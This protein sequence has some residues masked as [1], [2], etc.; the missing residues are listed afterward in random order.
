[1]ADIQ[2]GVKNY[3]MTI[4]E[5]GKEIIFLRKVEA[6]AA[7]KSYGIE[8]ARLAGLP[9]AVLRRAASILDRLEKK[10]IDLTGRSRRKPAEDMIFDEAQRSLF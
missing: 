4:Q 8:V 10:E 2:P 7:D 3:R 1:M 9:R 5:S 6:G